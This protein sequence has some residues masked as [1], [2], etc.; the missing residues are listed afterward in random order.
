MSTPK[1]GDTVGFAKHFLRSIH[2]S[3]TDPIWRERGTVVDIKEYGKTIP[4]IALVKGF[5][6]SQEDGL[7]HVNIKNIAVVGSLRH[8]E[9]VA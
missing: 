4:A 6:T 1:I 2:A 8:V 3:A 5:Q 9:D 7:A